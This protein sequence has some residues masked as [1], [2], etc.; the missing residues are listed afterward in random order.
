MALFRG[1]VG[2]SL[3]PLGSFQTLSGNHRRAYCHLGACLRGP[4]PFS[5]S[6]FLSLWDRDPEIIICFDFFFF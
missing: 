2:A 3:S 5:F 6:Q 4:P 1:R